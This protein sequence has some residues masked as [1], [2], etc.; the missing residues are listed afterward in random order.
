MPGQELHLNGRQKFILSILSIFGIFILLQV[1]NLFRHET[2]SRSVTSLFNQYYRIVKKSPEG[3]KRALDLI[4]ESDPHNKK[5]Q[6]EL[7][8]WYLNQGDTYRALKLF[9]ALQKQYPE[10]IRVRDQLAVLMASTNE[11]EPQIDVPLT[12]IPTLPKTLMGTENTLA[13]AIAS[14]SVT[15]TKKS[16]AVSAMPSVTPQTTSKQ[17]PSPPVATQSAR[18][19]LLNE[20]YQNK[21][22]HPQKA[23]HALYQLLAKYPNDVVAL[24]E[25]G[26][27]ALSEKKN[28]EAAFYFKRAYALTKDP[29]LAMQTGYILDGLNKKRE[30]YHYFDLATNNPNQEERLKAELA[31]TN[32]RG[33]QTQFLPYPY[34]ANIMFYPFYRSRFKLMI[35]PIIAKTGITLNEKYQMQLYL[36]YR[37]TSDNKS[38]TSNSLPQIFEDNAAITSIGFQS[39]LFPS[40]PLTAFIEAGKAVDL[41]YR[42]RARWRND[43][44]TGFFYYN[45]WGKQARYTFKPTL[46]AKPNMDIYAD[47]IYFSRFLNT[48]GTVRI[49]PGL[50][51]FRY[52]S[53]SLNAYMK[54]FLSQDDSR[55]FY[56]NFIEY[57]PSIAFTPSDRYNVT[58]RYENLHGLYLPAGGQYKNPYSNTYHNNMI[59]LDTYIGF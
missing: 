51:V 43:F 9:K 10:D 41:V 58:I 34:F 30:A 53:M 15:E 17:N 49:R 52:G 6:T 31:K 35:Y 5:A 33:V 54:G 50:E 57:G 4:L 37:R 46:S 39:R 25:A 19:K 36:S 12:P 1:I 13:T 14:A 2:V 40:I 38:N 28:Q 29:T 18:D 8:F 27:F 24:K 7:A 42:D 47:L 32:L 59:F 23:W 22:T 16:E 21:V 26:Y 48:I 56:N 3:A 55:Q 11:P 44:R 45:D 20:F